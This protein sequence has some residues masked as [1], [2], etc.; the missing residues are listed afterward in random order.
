M[1]GYWLPEDST[2][3]YLQGSNL[4]ADMADDKKQMSVDGE[5]L[6]KT[7]QPLLAMN[8]KLAEIFA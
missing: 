8:C 4:V 3:S 1:I 6:S 2:T 7:L 5:I